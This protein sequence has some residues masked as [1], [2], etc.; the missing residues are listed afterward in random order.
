MFR[1]GYKYFERN[2]SDYY[3]RCLY[4][5]IYQALKNYQPYLTF[6]YPS[7]PSSH[8]TEI[9]RYVFEDNPSFFYLDCEHCSFS[10]G[11]PAKI[12]FCYIYKQTE[13]Q[14]Y[15]EQ[16]KQI[17]MN[18]FDQYHV[19]ELSR[20][21]RILIFH[22]FISSLCKYDPIVAN[23][24]NG[25]K[26]DYNIIGVFKGKLAVCYGFS[27]VFK[28]LCDYGNISCL[29]VKGYCH[30]GGYHA[31]NMV[32]Y[33]GRYYHID[34]TW[35]LSKDKNN[36]LL[37][38]YTYF[39]VD[40]QWIKKTRSIDSSGQYPPSQGLE[41]TYFGHRHYMIDHSYQ[42]SD[43]I[44]KRLKEYSKEFIVYIAD[45]QINTEIVQQAYMKAKKQMQRDNSQFKSDAIFYID[46]QYSLVRFVL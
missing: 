14:S 32:E 37:G 22:N 40:D 6:D 2:L 44:Y 19:L 42:L 25:I 30:Q 9:L 33:K 17:I 13:I 3:E 15:E 28:L 41:N 7:I 23:G 26:E 5:R 12:I 4:Q 31:W 46:T 11:K 24:G 38:S 29:I 34:V 45:H 21:N 39:M 43:Y 27:Q 36:G 35:D 8:V 18:F 1:E 10:F 20:Y 16:I